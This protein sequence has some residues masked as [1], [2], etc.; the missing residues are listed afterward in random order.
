MRAFHLVGKIYQITCLNKLNY[1]RT[2]FKKY[3]KQLD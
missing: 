1:V 2:S 3:K